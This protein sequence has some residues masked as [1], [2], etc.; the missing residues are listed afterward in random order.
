MN[1]GRGRSA[2]GA[3]DGPGSA[4][5]RQSDRA[6][7]RQ[8]SLTGVAAALSVAAGLLLDVSIAARFGA[9]RATDSFF[10]AARIPIG[11]VAVVMVAANQALVPAF[12]T[13]LSKRGE[14]ATHRLIS[15]IITVVL[16]AGA[17]TVLVAWLAAAPLIRVTAP[18]IT[19][20]QA[21]T[22][23]SMVPVVFG[24]L[25]MIAVS[26]VMRAYLNSRYR[27]VAPA[28]MNVVLN[29][30]AATVVLAGPSLGWRHDV[31]LVAFAYL[32]GATAQLAFM[33]RRYLAGRDRPRRSAAWLLP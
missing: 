17:A 25:P 13:S 2:L 24:I 29:G 7:I 23:A 15:M 21:A 4:A 12:R 22:A 8:S 33:S 14:A 30:L 5:V 26:E 20:S 10:V 28:L 32:A 27:F 6:V 9:G 19:A 18:G 11:L 1:S 31:H 16:G 3:G